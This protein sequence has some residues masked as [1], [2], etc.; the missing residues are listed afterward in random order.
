M[1]NVTHALAGLLLAESAGRLRARRARPSEAEPP[2]RLRAVAAIASMVAANL[3]D[4]D[5]FYTGAGAD[6]LAYMLHH[7]GYTHT[8]V[9]ALLGAA[10]V[11]G[12]A[13]GAVRW[14]APTAPARGDA[15]WLLG[16]LVA[17]TLSHLVLDWTNSYGVHPFWPVDTRWRYGDAVFIVEPWL[18][19]VSVPALVAATTRRA[20]RGLLALVL[21]A[22][23]A[24]AWRVDLVS[25]GAA[26]AL[27]A[28]AALAVGLA[29]VLRPGARAAA[30]V[31]GWVAV[32]LVMAAG[33]AA[34]RA[35][36][37]RAV[38]VADPSAEVLDV[39]V[40]PLPANP[41]CAT[42][43]TV[44]RA[45]ATYRVATARVS[46]APIGHAGRALRRAGRRR[47]RVPAVFAAVDVG[48]AV[49]RGVDRAEC[50]HRHAGSGELPGA[51]GAAL[52]PRARLARGRRV[53]RPAGRR[54][55]RRRLGRRVHRPAGAAS[56]G[57]VPRRG[58]HRGRRRGRTCSG[59][60]T[61]APAAHTPTRRAHARVV[62]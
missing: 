56:V 6:R 61:D 25:A 29:R 18:W 48:G 31:A 15:G 54:A 50:G 36:T 20:A 30:A 49:G 41:V 51:R 60:G 28:G 42:V 13:W 1:D 8:V 12:A 23:L 44:E 59:V 53:D 40:S 10:L 62:S 58:S 2:P 26:A 38:R 4:A 24:L 3:P 5:L 27:T 39:V 37:L 47:A 57:E 14:R 35:T 21:L 52:P 22:G 9:L 55:L 19:V 45:G 34:A 33:G 16:L 17:S 7:R 11:W 43:I 46:A 32:T